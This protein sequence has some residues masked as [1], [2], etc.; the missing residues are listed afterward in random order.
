[1]I[2]LELGDFTGQSDMTVL[3]TL[4][5]LFGSK[6]A[7]IHS[8]VQSSIDL[9]GLHTATLT[10]RIKDIPLLPGDYMLSF[11]VGDSSDNLDRVQ[12]ALT[13]SITSADVYGT[14]KI[15]LRKDGLLALAA[16]WELGSERLGAN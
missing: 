9:N 11:A 1:V 4:S 7:Q 13:L 12:N 14:G 5:D 3:I 16:C 2:E 15:P 8:K 10:C 6:L